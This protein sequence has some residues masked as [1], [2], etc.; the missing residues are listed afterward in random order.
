MKSESVKPKLIGE[1]EGISYY[2]NCDDSLSK[3]ENGEYKD[4]SVYVEPNYHIIDRNGNE[5]ELDVIHDD[6]FGNLIYIDSDG[7][8]KF[9]SKDDYS[10]INI[11]K[12]GCFK[13]VDSR[14]YSIATSLE[15]VT[16]K[17][18]AKNEISMKRTVGA[19]ALL[20]IGVIGLTSALYRK[21]TKP[22]REYLESQ[23]TFEDSLDF[24]NGAIDSNI[25][26]DEQ[27]KNEFRY[28]GKR[29]LETMEPTTEDIIRLADKF[30]T[31]T[32]AYNNRIDE[33]G[34]IF[35]CEDEATTYD[36][37]EYLETSVP[38]DS[39]AYRLTFNK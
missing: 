33:Y 27:E 17:E 14:A 20:L 35:N 16:E 30:K 21:E 10:L 24:I 11:N 36:L 31:Y 5:L 38:E 29:Y 18:D 28:Y 19:A 3:F 2:R 22:I 26:T 15:Y 8:V 6:D 23:K 25:M 13:I 12:V 37:L 39:L 7:L 9:M 4:I 1:Y 32:S 34:Y